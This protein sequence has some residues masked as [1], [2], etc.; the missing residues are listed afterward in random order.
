MYFST[1]KKKIISELYK[2]IDKVEDSTL[3]L[4]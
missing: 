4:G 1:E 3:M 2:N